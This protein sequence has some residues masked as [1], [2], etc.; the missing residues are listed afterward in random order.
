MD[1]PVYPLKPIYSLRSL[2]KA[3][4]EPV[5]LLQSL[6]KRRSNLYRYVPQ[7]KKDGT[8]RHTYDA[9][10]PLKQVQRRIVDQILVRVV[11]PEYLHGGIRDVT[12]RRSIYSNAG[13]HGMAKHLVLQDIRDFYPSIRITHVQNTFEKLFGF[14]PEVSQL[15]A[16][17]TTYNE[18]V[19][20][21]ASTSSYLANLVFWDLEPALVFQLNKMGLNYTRFADDITIS[22][23]QVIP[24]EQITQ[25]IS[26]VTR[27]LALKGCFQKRK[28]LHIRKRGQRIQE[29]NEFE[30]LTVTGLTVFNSTPGVPKRERKAIRAAV[31]QIEDQASTG[32]PWEILAPMVR[33]TMGRVG[34][35]IACSHPEGE[36]LKQRL[37]ALNRP[38]L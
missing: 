28:K 1:A 8:A 20:Q 14:S 2:S 19:P 9:Y 17:L 4:G 12:K 6:A 30:P 26:M 22:S 16:E 32:V 18:A 24:K 15:L 11:F 33:K 37:Q 38:Q 29:N 25:I 5:S 3:L 7:V 36:K 34:R 21:G 10:E 23:I 13:P 31:K 35:L 27:M